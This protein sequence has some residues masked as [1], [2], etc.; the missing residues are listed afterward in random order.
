MVVF[1]SIAECPIEAQI[2]EMNFCQDGLYVEIQSVSSS[3]TT[4]FIIPNAQLEE[5]KL[6][7]LKG[8]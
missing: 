2:L 5:L 3:Q 1:K 8:E 6:F 7:I 4:N